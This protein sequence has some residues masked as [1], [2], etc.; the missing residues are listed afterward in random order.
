VIDACL[1]YFERMSPSRL[2]EQETGMT[3]DD[4]FDPRVP[5]LSEIDMV[6][7]LSRDH[8]EAYLL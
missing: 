1:L 8:P 4:F 3:H 5:M 7:A 6:R 2:S